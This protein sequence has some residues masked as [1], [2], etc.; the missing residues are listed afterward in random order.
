MDRVREL[1]IES[2]RVPRRYFD[3]IPREVDPTPP[4]SEPV[5]NLDDDQSDV[6]FGYGD[7][8]DLPF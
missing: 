8:D 3:N 7:G 6:N 4:P 1:I 5:F 2:S